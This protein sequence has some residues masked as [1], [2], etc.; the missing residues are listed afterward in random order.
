MDHFR[1]S[2][3]GYRYS[4]IQG[5][6]RGKHRPPSTY[7]PVT[8]MFLRILMIMAGCQFLAAQSCTVTSPTASSTVSAM[9]TLTSTCT[10]T[11]SVVSVDYVLNG[12]QTIYRAIK[13]PTFSGIY[14]SGFQLDGP[15]TIRVIA[16]DAFGST[17]ATSPDVAFTISNFGATFVW[18]SPACAAANTCAS[19]PISGTINIAFTGNHPGSALAGGHCSLDG[20]PLEPPVTSTGIGNFYP[21][22]PS[23]PLSVDTT[24]V[25][26][27]IHLIACY[28]LF[29]DVPG[30]GGTIAAPRIQGQFLADIEN[31]HAVMAVQPNINDIVMLVGDI[32]QLAP[33][34]AYTDNTTASFSPTYSILHACVPTDPLIPT[35]PFPCTS[36]GLWPNVPTSNIQGAAHASVSGTGLITALALG[37]SVITITDPTSGKVAYVQVL[38]KN[39]KTVAHFGSDGTIKHAVDSK[40]IFRT[41]L[42]NLPTITSEPT[43]PAHIVRSKY[44][45]VETQYWRSPFGYPTFAAWKADWEA[46]EHTDLVNALSSLPGLCVTLRSDGLM[47]P[48]GT[49]QDAAHGLWQSWAD[50]SD[51][52]AYALNTIKAS[53]L[54]CGNEAI[55]EADNKGYNAA[56]PIFSDKMSDGSIVKIVSDGAGTATVT[57][58][59]AAGGYP[60]NTAL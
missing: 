52:I 54:L 45:S 39:Y 15:A 38:V 22:N 51:P 60:A 35:L 18:T 23:F 19:S 10:N 4:S 14:N 47:G 43:L 34:L 20:Q 33:L 25:K 11:P 12:F 26:N 28:M 1:L 55:D 7:L 3:L 6:T 49:L 40:S 30:N 8:Q 48:A 31:G 56:T 2:V 53:G 42:F 50:V 46:N 24:M 32:F 29:N 58:G 57:L 27:G 37:Q 5:G 36:G 9:L 44:T 17:L 16:K 21:G 13:N 41:S 59:A